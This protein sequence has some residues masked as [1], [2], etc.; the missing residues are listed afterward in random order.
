MNPTGTLLD[1]RDG[2]VYETV[3][4]GNQWWMSEN[5]D[6][7]TQIQSFS[8]GSN[9]DGEMSDNQLIEKYCYYNNP[10]YCEMYGGLY[11]W[12]EAVNYTTQE[13]SRGICPEGW[14]VPSRA[15]FET[16]LELYPSSKD[17][18]FDGGSGFNALL[19]G[20]KFRLYFDNINELGL[21]WTSSG[22]SIEGRYLLVNKSEGPALINSDLQ[23]YGLSIRCVADS[24]Q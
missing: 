4:I 10:T 2:K 21:F 18:R 7:G 9:Q 6:I 3:K 8:G 22:G 1:E 5:L 24:L 11:Q 16:L 23:R 19:A 14:H 15:E 17:L 13:S 12:Q 20:N